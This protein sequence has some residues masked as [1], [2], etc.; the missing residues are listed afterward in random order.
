MELTRERSQVASLL[1]T[2]RG[3]P[4]PP[5]LPCLPPAPPL[6][7]VVVVDRRGEKGPPSLTA[8][9]ERPSGDPKDRAPA[10][11][12]GDFSDHGKRCS[13]DGETLGLR[14]G[15]GPGARPPAARDGCDDSEVWEVWEVWDDP[16]ND[17]RLSCSAPG[18]DVNSMRLGEPYS[19]PSPG[20][21]DRPVRC[22]LRCISSRRTS[23]SCCRRA[24]IFR[25]A[26]ARAS[27]A[28]QPGV[29][30]DRSGNR[31]DSA[32]QLLG[33]RGCAARA[34]DV[35]TMEYIL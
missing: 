19:R 16:D 33:L 10:P 28:C 11:A 20:R 34:A 5:N 32:T 21:C 12:G 24:S 7:V 22:A 31:G 6:V 1:H 14:L 2:S 9:G 35:P 18:K 29:R 13:D 8:C 17:P 30:G 3:P 15:L 4:D 26:L 27:S 25:S 23:S